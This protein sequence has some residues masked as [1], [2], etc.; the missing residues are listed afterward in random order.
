MDFPADG[1]TEFPSRVEG[2]ALMEQAA[3]AQASPVVR[4]KAAGT[5]AEDAEG[6]KVLGG[7]NC[8]QG[9]ARGAASETAHTCGRGAALEEAHTGKA[10]DAHGM[11]GIAQKSHCMPRSRCQ[12]PQSICQRAI[13]AHLLAVHATNA[14]P[15]PKPPAACMAMLCCR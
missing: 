9:A 14:W 6:R 2:E 5:A 8:G 11:D 1:H 15:T 10:T 13:N 3:R 12:A 4:G 7:S